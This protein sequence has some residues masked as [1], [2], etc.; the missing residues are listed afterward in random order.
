MKSIWQKLTEKPGRAWGWL[1]DRVRRS[2]TAI[3]RKLTEKLGQAKG[4]LQA[5]ARGPWTAIWQKLTDTPVQVIGAVVAAPFLIIA[6]VFVPQYQVASIED[7]AIRLEL[8]ND[9]RRTLAQIIGGA[10]GLVVIWITWQRL[11]VAR[12][13]L[14]IAREGQITERYSRAIEHLGNKESLDVRVEAIYALERTARDSRQDHGPIMEILTAYVREH[15]QRDRPPSV[16]QPAADEQRPASFSDE[17]LL[18][19]SALK[20]DIQAALTV[21]GRRRTNYDPPRQVLNLMRTDLCGANLIQASLQRALLGEADLQKAK[22]WEANLQGVRLIRASL[23]EANFVN[24]NLQKAVFVGAQLQHAVL[25]EADLRGALFTGASLD[26]AILLLANLQK[27]VLTGADLQGASFLLADL[28]SADLK[29]ANLQKADFQQANL[30][31][32]DLSG[33][34]LQEATLFH[35]NLQGADLTEADLRGASL[36]RASGLTSQQLAVARGDNT[37]RLPPSVERPAHWP[38][39]R[40]DG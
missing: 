18:P 21:L 30:R 8:E 5:K 33:A 10:I 34:N 9:A 11:Q 15:A 32:A 38:A 19:T 12:E 29:E 39:E 17:D 31:R 16:R 1:W 4:W 25:N 22:L 23:R 14:Q 24:A 7:N 35:A 26:G 13:E 27:A 20:A 6:L 2:R 37:T 36:I 40:E 28:Q 3:R